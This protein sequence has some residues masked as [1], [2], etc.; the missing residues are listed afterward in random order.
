[1]IIY[2]LVN[3]AHYTIL[4]IHYY[5]ILMSHIISQNIIRKEYKEYKE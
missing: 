4:V 5:T 3:S 2:F 1:M